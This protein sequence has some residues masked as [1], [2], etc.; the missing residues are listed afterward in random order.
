M[1]IIKHLFK[2]NTRFVVAVLYTIT[3]AY[4]SLVNSNNL[5]D[6]SIKGSDKTL[7][8]FAYFM[9]F[10]VWFFYLYFRSNAKLLYTSF[11]LFIIGTLFGIIIEV[12]QTTITH[13]RQADVYDIIAN[14]A[15]LAVAGFAVYLFRKKII[16]LKTNFSL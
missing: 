13:S 5:P 12:L 3:I 6:F 16:Q 7:H 4:G 10:I 11:K 9:L 8:F 14:C 2:A 15:G 1:K